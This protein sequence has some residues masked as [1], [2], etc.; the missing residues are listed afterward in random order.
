MST[1]LESV[2]RTRYTHLE[3]PYS[4]L[5]KVTQDV[6]VTNTT[7]ET[8]ILKVSFIGVLLTIN[9]QVLTTIFGALQNMPGGGNN[10]LTIRGKWGGVLVFERSITIPNG[11]PAN[12]DFFLRWHLLQ[13]GDLANQ[14][15]HFNMVFLGGGLISQRNLVNIPCLQT[16][17][18]LIVT[19]QWATANPAASFILQWANVIREA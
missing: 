3:S 11:T 16:N 10:T 4:V 5:H 8:E 12:T 1:R 9:N 17:Q 15:S 18:D 14:V 19:A 13:N 7:V 6:V 2:Q